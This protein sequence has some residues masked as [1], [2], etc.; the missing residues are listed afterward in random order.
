MIILGVDPGIGR[1]GWA[2][3]E[4]QGS[5]LKPVEFGCIETSPTL[6]IEK[7]I[8]NV[9]SDMLRIIRKHK[10]KVLAI[11]ELFFGNN[12]KTAFAVGQARGAILLAASQNN[13]QTEVFNPMEVKMA[14]TGYGK[15]EKA[16]IGQMVKVILKLKEIPKLDD[17][18]DALAVA[19]AYAFSSKLRQKTK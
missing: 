1:C 15:A 14:L 5:N 19:I 7:R 6:S 2:V 12:A 3:L 8:E 4:A 10:P 13:I 11:E 17:T 9:Y 18:S 16:Q